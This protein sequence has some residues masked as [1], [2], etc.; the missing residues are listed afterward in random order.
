MNVDLSRAAI[1]DDGEAAA[2]RRELAQLFD[3]HFDAVHRFC[4]ARSGDVA[5]ADD[6]ASEAFLAAARR[7]AAGDGADVNRP[8]LLVVA[9]RRLYD[10]FRGLGRHERRVRRLTL[11][12]GSGLIEDPVE[13]VLDTDAVLTALA[14]LPERQRAALA[15]RYLDEFSVTEVA[16]ALGIGYEAAESLLARGRRSFARAWKE[17]S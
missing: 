6:A 16:D 2:A 9:R 10:Q 8:W 13:A 7:F 14:S 12:P 3:E 1:S 5:V 11:L 4:L 15:L 17:Q